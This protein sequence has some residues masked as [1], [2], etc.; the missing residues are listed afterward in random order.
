MNRPRYDNPASRIS[1]SKRVSTSRCGPS[2]DGPVLEMR[3]R[4]RPFASRTRRHSRRTL[5]ALGSGRCAKLASQQMLAAD[6]FLSGNVS[7]PAHSCRTRVERS[8]FANPTRLPDLNTTSTYMVVFLATACTASPAAKAAA[9]GTTVC[10]IIEQTHHA[11]QSGASAPKDAVEPS[12][13]GV[14][15]HVFLEATISSQ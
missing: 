11:L 13:D 8:R 1:R 15:R 4:K 7:G 14:R 9:S 12:L 10:S 3:I 6:R 2:S 5:R